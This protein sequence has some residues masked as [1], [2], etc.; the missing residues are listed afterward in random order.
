M[1]I[2]SIHI[3][4]YIPEMITILRA[5]KGYSRGSQTIGR[6]PAGGGGGSAADPLGGGRDWSV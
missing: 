5:C 3:L 2:Y 4:L 6:A 1:C